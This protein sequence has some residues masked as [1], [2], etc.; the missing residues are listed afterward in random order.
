VSDDGRAV[1]VK[2]SPASTRHRTGQPVYDSR[3]GPGAIS[4]TSLKAQ[5]FY[6]TTGAPP[7]ATLREYTS[8][9]GRAPI[10]TRDFSGSNRASVPLGGACLG[11]LILSVN[12]QDSTERR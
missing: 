12:S 7:K 4:S 8:A 5:G 3:A 10:N 1:K 9:S 6:V 2:S 11:V